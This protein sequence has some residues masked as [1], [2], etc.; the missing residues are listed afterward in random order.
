MGKSKDSSI[1]NI[2]RLSSR[3]EKSYKKLRKKGDKRL[4]ELVNE[5]IDKLKTDEKAGQEL[6]QDLK[7]LYSMHISQFSYRIVYEVKEDNFEGIII[8]VYA[9]SHRKSV[10]SDLSAYLKQQKYDLD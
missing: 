5:S 9:I 4:L 3:C 6:Y 1:E 7:G 8:T 2:V 10:Y